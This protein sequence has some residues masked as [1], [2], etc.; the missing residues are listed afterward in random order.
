[1][2]IIIGFVAAL[3][4]PLVASP[5]SGGIFQ[6]EKSVIAGGGGTTASGL[7]SLSGTIGQPVVTGGTLL[8]VP[9]AIHGGFWTPNVAGPT[10]TPTPTPTGTPSA[11][12]TATP[13]STPTSTP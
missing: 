9:F 12:P 2:R 5:Q 6:I 7:F 13:T 8:G 10:P 11:T 4:F 1:M 3:V